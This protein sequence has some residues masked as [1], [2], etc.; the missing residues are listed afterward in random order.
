M[1]IYNISQALQIEKILENQKDIWTKES[2][3]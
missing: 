2:D 3:C 1:S